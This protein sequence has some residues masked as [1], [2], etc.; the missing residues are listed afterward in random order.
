M[1]NKFDSQQPFSQQGPSFQP[2]YKQVEDHLRQLIIDRRWKLGEVLPN[3]FKLADEFNVSQGTVRKALNALTEANILYRKQGVGTFISEHTEQNALYRFFPIVSDDGDN[4]SPNSQ[5][6]SLKVQYPTQEVAEALNLQEGDKVIYFTRKRE[7]NG[8]VCI[9]EDINLPVKYFD[10]FEQEAEIPHTL[11]QFYQAKFDQVVQET[12][13]KI[14]AV[15]ADN[16][17][18]DMLAIEV[19]S[20]LILFTRVAKTLDGRYI[21]YRKTRCRSDKYH[22]LVKLD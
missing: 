7:I 3:E 2:L 22:Y 15:L 5:L 14:K 9:L 1:M 21:E 17:D 13:D 19:G 10:G 4:N 18:A 6:L 20:P 16:K 12:S 11:Y 8:E